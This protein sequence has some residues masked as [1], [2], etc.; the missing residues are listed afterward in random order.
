MLVYVCISVS[1]E[2]NPSDIHEAV[3]ITTCK[4]EVP[5]RTVSVTLTACKLEVPV[6][7][8][9]VTLTACKLEVQY[10]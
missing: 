3:T 5:V 10:H 1:H 2:L 9:S 4:L 6:R 7:T 8:A